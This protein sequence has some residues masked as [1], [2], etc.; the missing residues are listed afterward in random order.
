MMAGRVIIIWCTV[1]PPSP[2]TTR[3]LALARAL[4]L[5]VGYERGRWVFTVQGEGLA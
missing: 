3:L 5:K 2:D 4:D 1:H